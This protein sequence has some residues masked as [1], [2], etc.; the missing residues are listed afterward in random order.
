[1]DAKNKFFS[2]YITTPANV[3]DSQVLEELID[4]DDEAVF[5][6]SAY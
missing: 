2:A 6:D 1:V 4:E 5:A 3:H